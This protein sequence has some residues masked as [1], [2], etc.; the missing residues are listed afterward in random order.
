MNHDRVLLC[1]DHDYL[2]KL[3]RAVPTDEQNPI[4]F[5]ANDAERQGEDRTNISLS[6]TVTERACGNLDLH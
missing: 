2:E 6:D 3:T 1:V 4:S 5:N